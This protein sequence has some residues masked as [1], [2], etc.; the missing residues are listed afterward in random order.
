MTSLTGLAATLIGGN[1]YKTL[2]NPE[3]PGL[4]IENGRGF[5]IG[6]P[7][8]KLHLSSPVHRQIQTSFLITLKHI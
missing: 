4:G 7:T 6:N 2:V 8:S 5:G 1:N 3:I